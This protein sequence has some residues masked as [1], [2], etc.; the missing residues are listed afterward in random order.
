MRSKYDAKGSPQFWKI[1]KTKHKRKIHITSSKEENTI[2]SKYFFKQSNIF[3]ES[4]FEHR[5]A[6]PKSGLF[7]KVS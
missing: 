3:P 4:V 1:L 2:V 5:T 7:Y 6:E